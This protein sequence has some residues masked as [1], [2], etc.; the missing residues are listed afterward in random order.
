MDIKVSTNILCIYNVSKH[1]YSTG[2]CSRS[3]PHVSCFLSAGRVVLTTGQAQRPDV[4]RALQLATLLYSIMDSLPGCICVLDASCCI[5][6][7]VWSLLLYGSLHCI[8]GNGVF[9]NHGDSL[10]NIGVYLYLFVL[11]TS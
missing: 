6:R 10:F 9:M 5:F 1:T 4:G 8:S 11:F 3:A 7:S 2:L